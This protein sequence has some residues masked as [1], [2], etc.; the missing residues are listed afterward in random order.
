[1]HRSRFA[2][3]AGL[4]LVAATAAAVSAAT[5]LSGTIACDVNPTSVLQIALR[6]SL[7]NSAPSPT[8]VVVKIPMSGICDDSGVV[9]GNAPITH[10]DARIRAR[11]EA[12]STCATLLSPG[13]PYG[14]LQIKLKWRSFDGTR[15]KT[16]GASATHLSGGTYDAGSESIVFTAEIFR[17]AFAGSTSTIKLKLQDPAL[18]SGSCPPI[19]G[20]NWISGGESTLTVK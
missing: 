8:R 18:L 2:L 11:L 14:K 19:E 9:G 6:P 16:V 1:M 20:V 3:A 10:V 4:A 15:F 13:F 5:S 12:G 17:G 7:T